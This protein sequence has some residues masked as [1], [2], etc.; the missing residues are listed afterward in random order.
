M[1]DY[2]YRAKDLAGNVKEGILK[3]D[4][5]KVILERL[6]RLSYFPIEI[7]EQ[8]KASA[9]G[10]DLKAETGRKAGKKAVLNFTKKMANLL[11]AG[12]PVLK[13]LQIVRADAGL[14]PVIDAVT[15]GLKAGK[16]MSSVMREFKRAFP[17]FYVNMVA[18]GEESG[19]LEK[20]FKKLADQMEKSSKITRELVTSM[21][22]PLFMALTGALS[23][24]VLMLL[25][26]PKF[27]IL[28]SSGGQM[29]PLPTRMLLSFS[30]FLKSYIIHFSLGAGALCA[31]AYYALS[32]EAYK[33]YFHRFLL[34]IP[35]PGGVL[36]KICLARFAGS[37]HTLLSGGVNLIPSLEY[38][39]GTTGNLY[40]AERIK[41][42]GDKIKEG[43]TLSELCAKED[44]CL[45]DFSGMLKVGEETGRMEDM[46]LRISEMYEGDINSAAKALISFTEPLFIVLASIIVG[47]IVIS[48][49]LPVFSIGEFSM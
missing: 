32:K 25:V 37:L 40:F 4:N 23:V 31:A 33:Y 21:I 49:L 46:L 48:M 10:R 44:I 9:A 8:G 35:V 18:A 20:S 41:N 47:F 3:A 39:A 19:H 24:A 38:A 1:P 30:G 27:V 42:I 22:Y 7:R 28:Y 13:A 45:D 43:R 29:L 5:E 17:P 36:K 34:R 14:A 11:E 16:N 15:G 2:F 6:H 26:V 12:I